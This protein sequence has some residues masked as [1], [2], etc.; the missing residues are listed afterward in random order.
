MEGREGTDGWISE[1]GSL[2][3]DDNYY[4][5]NDDNDDALWLVP[6]TIYK[7]LQYLTSGPPGLPA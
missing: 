5:I 7:P 6:S 4:D 3:N 1:V 2:S